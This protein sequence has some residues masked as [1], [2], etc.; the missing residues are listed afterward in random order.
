MK[1]KLFQYAVIYHDKSKSTST[2]SAATEYESKVVIE[3]KTILAATEK[4]VLFRATREIDEQYIK[5][6]DDVEII[7][8]NF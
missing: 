2:G 4:E 1:K 8:R 7:I 5:N 3:P 6:P